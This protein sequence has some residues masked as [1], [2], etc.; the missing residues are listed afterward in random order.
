MQGVRNVG[1]PEVF[2]LDELGR[3]TLAAHP[4]GRRVVTDDRAGRFAAVAGDVLTTP[5]GADIAPTRYRDWLQRQARPGT[6]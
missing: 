1:G 3:I 6:S 2:P 4:D 5:E